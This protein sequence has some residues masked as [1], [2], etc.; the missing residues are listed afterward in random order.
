MHIA[1]RLAFLLFHPVFFPS[2][3]QMVSLLRPNRPV[4]LTGTSAIRQVRILSKFLFESARHNF[5]AHPLEPPNGANVI[6]LVNSGR[7]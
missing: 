6:A 5:N 1:R 3:I 2:Q 4:E 7:Y